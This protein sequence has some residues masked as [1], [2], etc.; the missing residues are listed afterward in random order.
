MYSDSALYPRARAKT[1][2]TDQSL[3]DRQGILN[4]FS[5]RSWILSGS[6]ALVGL[7]IGVPFL[8]LSRDR[9]QAPQ[10]L[11]I[12]RAR[13]HDGGLGSGVP[14][15]N[16]VPDDLRQKYSPTRRGELHVA[17]SKDTSIILFPRNI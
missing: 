12:D 6:V 9:S 16:I 10:A 2:C 14:H 3:T 8:L 5:R 4:T 15:P 11:R 1:S 7:A 13:M 17:F